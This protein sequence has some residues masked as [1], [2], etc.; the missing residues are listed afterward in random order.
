MPSRFAAIHR[1]PGSLSFNALTS[2]RKPSSE[3]GFR[4]NAAANRK[5]RNAF[6]IAAALSAPLI[7][8]N[9]VPGWLQWMLATPVQL[10]SGARF[11][12][13]AWKALRGGTANM[14]VLVALGSSASYLF[15]TAALFLQLDEHLYFE[16]GAVVITLVLLGKYLEARAKAKAAQSLEGLIRL[17]PKVAFIERNGQVAQVGIGLDFTCGDA[18]Y[19]GMAGKID[20][21]GDDCGGGVGVRSG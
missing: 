1:T 8:H 2:A 5:A 20:G 3:L 16:A 4:L 21:V 7:L 17:Q 15:S 6:I 14:D 12:R 11:Y 10:Y 19:S 13:G 9:L 18:S